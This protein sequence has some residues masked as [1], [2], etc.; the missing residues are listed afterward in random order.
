MGSLGSPLGIRSNGEAGPHI[1]AFT[2][3]VRNRYPKCTFKRGTNFPVRMTSQQREPSLSQGQEG[4]GA[5]RGAM[6]YTSYEGNAWGCELASSGV[7][8]L[9]D[10]WLEGDLVFGGLDFIFK[11]TKRVTRPETLD[12]DQI[13]RETD[14]ILLTMGIDDHAH[15]PTLKRLPK[16]I[17]VVGSPSAAAVA[18]EL[19]YSTVL[20]VRHGQHVS[21]CD[22]KIQIMATEGAL[23]GPPWSLR[24][25]G[26][27]ISETTPGGV[28]LYYEPHADYVP[29]SVASV[30]KVD[31]VVSPPCTQSLLGY[32]LVKGSTDNVP[33]LELLQPKAVVALMNAE[34]DASGPLHTLLSETGSPEDLE[35]QL[36]QSKEL[37]Q[38]QLVVPKAG[39]PIQ[40]HT[41]ASS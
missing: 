11:G 3:V 26:Y 38:I 16:S 10:P 7:K 22:G 15:R 39:Q 40:V 21:M 18:R 19:G 25:N 36:K 29:S 5:T 6:T 20:E 41:N 24:E 32:Q 34:F 1:R 9:V 12:I 13:A 28:R 31:I 17:P 14:F 30:G 35:R 37:S 2:P 23:V 33:L 27:V 4:Q 8:F